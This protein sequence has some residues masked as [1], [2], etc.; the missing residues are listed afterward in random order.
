MMALNQKE[1]F[2]DEHIVNVGRMIDRP[3][4]GELYFKLCGS[5]Q[6]TNYIHAL[7]AGLMTYFLRRHKNLY[8][9]ANIGFEAFVGVTRAYIGRRT[10]RG[11][12]AGRVVGQKRSIAESVKDVMIRTLAWMMAESS[13]NSEEVLGEYVQN[14]KRIRKEKGQR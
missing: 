12:H 5:S 11:D 3:K 2:T 10:T 13:P 9:Y 14:R 4:W 1:D 7:I 8:R 6:V